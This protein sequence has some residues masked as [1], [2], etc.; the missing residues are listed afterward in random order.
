MFRVSYDHT[1]EEQNIQFG[2]EYRFGKDGDISVFYSNEKFSTNTRY[3]L[4]N[5]EFTFNTSD[6]NQ[7]LSITNYHD[8]FQSKIVLTNTP[9]ERYYSARSEFSLVATPE[10]LD[11]SETIGKSAFVMLQTD[12][13]FIGKM[14]VEF[15]DKSCEL[16]ADTHCTFKLS[17]GR[18]TYFAYTLDD[19]PLNVQVSPSAE[20][21]FFAANGSGKTRKIF[22]KEVF[23]VS[24]MLTVDGK[25]V[26]LLIAEIIDEA[27]TAQEI[28]TDEEG[29]FFAELLEGTYTLKMDEIISNPFTIDATNAVEGAD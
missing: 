20:V 15:S 29:G 13:D 11:I 8:I 3:R 25:K 21:S 16:S 1:P 23:F 22:T 2:L 24:G 18:D 7:D 12:E 4:D 27:G 28:F 10:G 26:N 19:M 17:G 6:T 5:N 9:E 14:D